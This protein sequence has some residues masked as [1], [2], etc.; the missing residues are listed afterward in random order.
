MRGMAT[1]I[2][3]L[4]DTPTDVVTAVM[5]NLAAGTTYSARYVGNERTLLKVL[6]SD[7]APDAN[8]PALPVRTF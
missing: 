7:M 4:T 8:D 6:E 5:P 1:Q 3:N 2:Y